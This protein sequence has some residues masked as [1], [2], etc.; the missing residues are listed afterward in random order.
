MDTAKEKGFTLIELMLVVAIMV[1]VAAIA[2]PLVQSYRARAYETVCIADGQSAY[3][4]AVQYF[5]DHSC[6]T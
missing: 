3:R 6:A 4:A 5:L 2:I 1:L